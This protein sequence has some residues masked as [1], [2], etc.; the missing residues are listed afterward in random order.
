MR[1]EIHQLHPTHSDPLERI[2]EIAER[3]SL[4]P[5]DVADMDGD[6]FDYYLSWYG[7]LNDG[8][9]IRMGR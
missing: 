1:G 2:F 9:Q 4:N 7:G 5:Q 8:R 3:F 6:L